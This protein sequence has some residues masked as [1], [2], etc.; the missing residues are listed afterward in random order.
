MNLF[1]NIFDNPEL[2]NNCLFNN[3]LFVTISI[4]LFISI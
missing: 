1:W 4:I 2:L 3:D